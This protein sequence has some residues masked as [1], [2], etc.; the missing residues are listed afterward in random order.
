MRVQPVP[1]FVSF[2][3]LATMLAL[4][5]PSRAFAELTLA[6]SF[7]EDAEGFGPN[8]GGVTI[9]RDTIGATVGTG[10]LRMQIVQG[11]TFVGAL[12]GNLK[13]EVGDPPGM[14]AIVFDLTITQQFPTEL[15]NFVDAGITFF[16]SSQPDLPGGQ[17]EGLG[18]QFQA[19]QVSL[20]GLAPGTH[21]ITMP[22]LHA[23]HPLTFDTNQ[24]FNQI[25]GGLGTGINDVIPTGFQIYINKSS[26]AAWTG[27]IDN[28]R[29]GMLPP[30]V[31]ADFN[32]D[33]FVNALDLGI[34]K[35]A[36]GSTVAGDANGDL[37]SDGADFLIWQRQFTPTAGPLGAVPEPT[38]LSLGG[39]AAAM[40]VAIRRRVTCKH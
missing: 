13:P 8:G 26:T 17:L 27:Y 36:Y 28:I 23:V 40:L 12:T 21:T 37:R 9:A 19:D 39:A 25:F 3:L 38:T 2:C 34:W 5:S 33:G 29:V 31:D 32:D 6:Y 7:E 14:D 11:A 22:L 20:G 10:S 16:G 24:T 4:V 1:C 15:G 18:V 30:P 35:G